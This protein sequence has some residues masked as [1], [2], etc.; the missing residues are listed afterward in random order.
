MASLLKAMM[1]SHQQF[2]WQCLKDKLSVYNPPNELYATL[3]LTP[4]RRNVN[5]GAI[6]GITTYASHSLLDLNPA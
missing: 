4:G 2:N 3:L 5:G 6:E 1:S